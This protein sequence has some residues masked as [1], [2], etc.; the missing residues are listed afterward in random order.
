MQP[1]A[2]GELPSLEAEVATEQRAFAVPSTVA[3]LLGRRKRP[4]RRQLIRVRPCSDLCAFAQLTDSQGH[5]M[6]RRQ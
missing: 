4:P 2:V 5:R 6:T 1:V 3:E